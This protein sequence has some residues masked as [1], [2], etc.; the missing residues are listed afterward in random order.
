MHM[1]VTFSVWLFEFSLGSFGALCKIHD[2]KIFNR[3]LLPQ[4]SS[5]FKQTLEKVC[6]WGKYR[7][8]LF[9]AVCQNLKVYGPL[10]MLSQLHIAILIH[11]AML[12]SSG[13]RSS[14]ASRPLV[15]G[16]EIFEFPVVYNAKKLC[17]KRVR[18][19]KKKKEAMKA[20][21]VGFWH[22]HSHKLPCWGKWKK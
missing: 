19:T 3:L 13:K 11:E 5:I 8:L 12:V 7:S 21:G 18:W 6:N 2:V 1:P 15:G 20:E 22:F 17:L 16:I 14:R 9:L 10:K 4:F